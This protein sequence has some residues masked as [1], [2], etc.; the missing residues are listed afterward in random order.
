[1]TTTTKTM[2]ADEL[3]NMPDDS[4]RYELVRGELRKMAPAGHD[5][6]RI[7]A[8]VAARLYM[9]VTGGGLGRV[10]VA[11]AGFKLGS[12]PDHVR[13]P[14][15]AFVRRERAEA[16]RGTP[17]FFPGAPDVAVEVVSPSDSYT[18]VEEKVEDWLGA[19]TLAVIVVDPRRRTVKVHRSLADAVVLTEAD[20]LA[21]EDIVPGWRMPVQDIF[22]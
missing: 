21:I 10:Y 12:D 3:L 13:A 22:K 6:G 2:T 19:G 1:M 15:A 9:H 5:H 14:D 18:E 20:V 11:E 17:G 16:A 4:F 8:S 7:A